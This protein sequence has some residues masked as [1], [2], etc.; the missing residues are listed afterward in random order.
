MDGSM[1]KVTHDHLGRALR[2]EP[3]VA[4]FIVAA[5]SPAHGGSSSAT[6][7]AGAVKAA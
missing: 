2:A 7:I 1:S 4:P 3:E 6:A 5:R